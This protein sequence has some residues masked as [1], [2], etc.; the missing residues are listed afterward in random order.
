[1]VGLRAHRELV[2]DGLGTPDFTQFLR[3]ALALPWD[4]PTPL[5]TNKPRLL[6]ISRRRTRLLLNLAAVVHAA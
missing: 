5:G 1:V 6:I 4:A 3:R 2:A